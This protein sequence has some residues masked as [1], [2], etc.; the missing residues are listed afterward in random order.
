MSRFF[1]LSLSYGLINDYGA[2]GEYFFGIGYRRY[3]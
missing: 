2:N 3:F 1:G